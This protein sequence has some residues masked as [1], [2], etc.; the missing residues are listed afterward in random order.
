MMRPMG[1]EINLTRA[2]QII[3]VDPKYILYNKEQ[4]KIRITRITQ[5]NYIMAHFFVNYNIN[6]KRRIK[7][8]YC[9]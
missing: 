5:I 2:Q 4:V 7:R 1:I 6:I 9:K 3:I 8:C